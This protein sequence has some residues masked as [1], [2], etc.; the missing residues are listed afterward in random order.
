MATR[1]GCQFLAMS[2]PLTTCHSHPGG[3]HSK[4]N[5]HHWHCMVVII[6]IIIII[7]IIC[8]DNVY[9]AVIVTYSHC[10]SLPGSSDECRSVPGGRRPS[11]QANRLGCWARLYR[12]L[13]DLYPPSPFI[14][15]QPKADTHFKVPQRV[16]DWVNL[17]T[18]HA[19]LY[20]II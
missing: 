4:T 20:N 15:T 11:D 9:G 10:E 2:D 6:I 3:S 1:I 14:I 17:G 16:E 18:Q 13:Y 12:L 5:R 19:A 8:Q 7:I